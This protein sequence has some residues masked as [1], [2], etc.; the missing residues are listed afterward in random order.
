MCDTVSVS[1][2]NDVIAIMSRSPSYWAGKSF[3]YDTVSSLCNGVQ[4]YQLSVFPWD[5][6]VFLLSTLK[7]NIDTI[8]YP[9]LS[10]DCK[11]SHIIPQKTSVSKISKL[12]PGCEMGFNASNQWL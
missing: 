1:L 12:P 5:P 10:Q 8:C 11:L 2:P 4:A 6:P 9:C 7:G 3:C